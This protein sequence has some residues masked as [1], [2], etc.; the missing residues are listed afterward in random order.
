ME[1]EQQESHQVVTLVPE[2]L[3]CFDLD[4]DVRIPE[5]SSWGQKMPKCTRQ[6]RP[7]RP[8]P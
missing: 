8:V 5:H 7:D 2:D 3:L 6:K 4:S 1:L